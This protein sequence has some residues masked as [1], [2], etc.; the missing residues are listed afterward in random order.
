MNKKILNNIIAMEIV[1]HLL[2]VLL[3]LIDNGDFKS[4]NPNNWSIY[5]FLLYIAIQFVNIVSIYE[6]NYRSINNNEK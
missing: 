4:L 1:V 2:F 3:L 6:F 5:Q